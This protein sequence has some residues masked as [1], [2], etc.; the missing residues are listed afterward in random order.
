MPNAFSLD[1]CGPMTWRVEDCAIVLGAIAGADPLDPASAERPVP[2]YRAALF[3]GVKGLRV[4]AIR[5]FWEEEQ[6]ASPALRDAME[7]AI[8]VLRGLGAYV[9]EVRLRPITHYNAV[10][11][12]LGETEVYAVHHSNAVTRLDAFG[13]DFQKRILAGCLIDA[14]A[15]IQAQRERRRMISEIQPMFER[16]D[17]LLTA[18]GARGAVAFGTPSQPAAWAEAKTT[19][20]FNVLGLPALSLCN[21]FDAV[22]LPLGMQIIGRPFDEATVLRAAHAFEAA[23]PWRAHRPALLAG[24]PSAPVGPPPEQPAEDNSDR[25]VR[26]FV[27]TMLA[28]A[29]LSPSDA[30]RGAVYAA[31]PA[32]LEAI[33]SLPRDHAFSEE[34]AAAFSFPVADRGQ[35]QPAAPELAGGRR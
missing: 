33:G 12:A 6:P 26:A 9:E 11:I 25:S 14:P 10:K 19:A 24:A 17:V 4:G 27:D 7:D 28:R 22:G 2:D 16:C 15:Y 35:H 5:H 23:T 20:P 34:P 31:A 13:I 8:E 1:H 29:G 32:V 30:V 21:G 18:S 3:D